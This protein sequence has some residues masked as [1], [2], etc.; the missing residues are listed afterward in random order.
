MKTENSDN[1][2]STV[3]KADR[4]SIQPRMK[5]GELQT[6]HDIV[7]EQ[8]KKVEQAVHT[9]TELEAEIIDRLEENG[10][11]A[12]HSLE[13]SNLETNTAS[14]DSDTEKWPSPIAEVNADNA[15]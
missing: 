10:F 14:A 7:Q 8:R 5:D 6:A 11:L 12:E 3:W 4:E 13:R 2:G 9:Q 1:D 15:E